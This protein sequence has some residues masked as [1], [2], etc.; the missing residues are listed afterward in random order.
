ML[1]W[2]FLLFCYQTQLAFHHIEYLSDLSCRRKFPLAKS[3]TS[4]R[5]TDDEYF[6][7]RN[8]PFA[9]QIEI[10]FSSLIEFPSVAGRCEVVYG[11]SL[12]EESDDDSEVRAFSLSCDM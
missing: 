12:C 6:T 10:T 2:S 4:S 8:L 5:I 9:W 3:Q 11:K 7:N 1:D